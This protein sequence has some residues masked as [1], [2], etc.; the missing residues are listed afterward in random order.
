MWWTP[1]GHRGAQVALEESLDV[2]IPTR[3]SRAVRALRRGGL[4]VLSTLFRNG[5]RFRRGLVRGWPG[6]QCAGPVPSQAGSNAVGAF[7]GRLR[8]A[9]ALRRSPD[10]QSMDRQSRADFLRTAH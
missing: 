2:S 1:E 4:G 7:H 5:Q 8:E 3:D 10:L 6:S 9:D